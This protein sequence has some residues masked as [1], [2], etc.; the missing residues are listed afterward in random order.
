MT[1]RVNLPRTSLEVSQ[2]CFGANV[3]GWSIHDQREA[4][5]LLDYVTD[6][7]I[8]FFDTAD[9]YV[10]WHPGNH[11]GE[12]ELMLGQWLLDSGIPRDEVVI[13]TKV[14][15]MSSRPGLTPENIRRAA[16]ESLQRLGVEKIDLYYAH[17]DD[18][19][20]PLDET[21]GAFAE[22]IAQGQ[23]SHI[24]A[25]NY[26]L[27]RLN[28]ANEI[29]R[30]LGISE[31][32]AVQNHY[33]LVFRE[34]YEAG[35]AEY[36]E[37]NQLAGLPYFSLASGFLTGAYSRESQPD[38][39]RVQRVSNDY[40][41]DQNFD[42]LDR[43]NIVAARNGVEPATVALEWLRQQRG[44]TAPIASASRIDQVAPLLQ[45]IQLSPTDL[46]MLGTPSTTIEPQQQ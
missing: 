3:F 32:I 43:L 39:P 13:A 8:N 36:V 1:I 23:V 2:I 29:A 5:S 30:R 37:D 34:D 15:R 33:N 26:S 12:S 14:G 38:S 28:E 45:Q 20:V 35:M 27:E 25:S 17:F 24:A 22:L 42:T 46:A 16:A 7:G 44:V 19:S 4:S 41:S 40:F 11:G 31:Y 18:H 9:I 21:L 6:Q 10:E